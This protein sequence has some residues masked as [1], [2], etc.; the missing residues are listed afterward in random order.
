MKATVPSPYIENLR[1]DAAAESLRDDCWLSALPPDQQPPTAAELRWF[2][3]LLRRDEVQRAMVA[4]DQATLCDSAL[5]I[6][7]RIPIISGEG[8]ALPAAHRLY[9]SLEV[10]KVLFARPSSTLDLL[11]SVVVYSDAGKLIQNKRE[12]GIAQVRGRNHVVGRLKRIEAIWNALDPAVSL[13]G[14]RLGSDRWRDRSLEAS[15]KQLRFWTD[16]LHSEPQPDD[17]AQVVAFVE[18]LTTE[19]RPLLLDT[20][21]SLAPDGDTAS[22]KLQ[23]GFASAADMIAQVAKEI[24]ATRHTIGLANVASIHFSWFSQITGHQSPHANLLVHELAHVLDFENGGLDGCP[25]PSDC[26]ERSVAE[27]GRRWA[28]AYDQAVAGKLAL[29]DAYGLENRMEFFAVCTE[30]FF[31]EATS[32]RDQAPELFD[33]LRTTYGYVP[34]DRRRSSVFGTIKTLFLSRLRMF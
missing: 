18:T 5:A 13:A 29:V 31:T 1:N 17:E 30:H 7:R 25:S 6:E 10:A 16:R 32:L 34:S 12:A 15:R 19:L 11:R 3:S 2:S 9:I 20:A 33:L 28:M 24:V 14:K 22:R 4:S 23:E 27:F 21:R 26:D 8:H